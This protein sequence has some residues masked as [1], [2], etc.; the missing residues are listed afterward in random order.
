MKKIE[1]KIPFILKRQNKLQKI[2]LILTNFDRSYYPIFLNHRFPSIPSIDTA[3]PFPYKNWQISCC[4]ALN[5]QVWFEAW[6]K[7]VRW[8]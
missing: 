3:S 7:K 1:I 4:N 6:W 5:R 8:K 2:S